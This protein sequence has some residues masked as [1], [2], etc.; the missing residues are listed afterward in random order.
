MLAGG[1]GAGFDEKTRVKSFIE[2]NEHLSLAHLSLC[3]W[4]SY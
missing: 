4:M 1:R 2:S 3:D